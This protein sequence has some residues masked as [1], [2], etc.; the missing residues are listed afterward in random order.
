MLFVPEKILYVVLTKNALKRATNR[1]RFSLPKDGDEICRYLNDNA[2]S[3]YIAPRP[4][5][6]VFNTLYPPLK[7][8]LHPYPRIGGNSFRAATVIRRTGRDEHL[9]E[10]G[11]FVTV[12]WDYE[13]APR[14]FTKSVPEPEL[15]MV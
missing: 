13:R 10:H 2:S 11:P 14:G 6:F 1:D 12:V 5:G 3:G 15:A 7:A 9:I 4:E 8:F